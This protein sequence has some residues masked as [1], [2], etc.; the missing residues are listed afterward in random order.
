[1]GSNSDHDR[2]GCFRVFR[3]K[4]CRSKTSGLGNPV[5][6]I[7]RADRKGSPTAPFGRRHVECNCPGNP[8]RIACAA[9][10]RLALP[11]L[12]RHT[13]TSN[14][15]MPGRASSSFSSRTDSKEDGTTLL[16]GFRLAVQLG[17]ACTEITSN[18]AATPWE[19]LQQPEL[20]SCNDIHHGSKEGFVFSQTGARCRRQTWES[21]FYHSA[22][23]LSFLSLFSFLLYRDY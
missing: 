22:C 13:V 9:F 17:C 5:P 12:A 8:V 18:H 23:L 10:G 1:V 2:F 11:G 19:W 14:A 20:P 4:Q 16:P 21:A 15:K 3:V 7:G 6:E